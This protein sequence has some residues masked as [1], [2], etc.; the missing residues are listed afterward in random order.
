MNGRRVLRWAENGAATTPRVMPGVARGTRE[1]VGCFCGVLLH[2][3]GKQTSLILFLWVKAFAISPR[4][5]A[6]SPTPTRRVIRALKI[7]GH[8]VFGLTSNALDR[9]HTPQI[10]ETLAKYKIR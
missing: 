7:Q 8:S 2:P 4:F 9:V 1:P 10:L 6:L 3:L 5:G